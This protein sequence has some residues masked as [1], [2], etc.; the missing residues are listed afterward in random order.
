MFLTFCLSL[1]LSHWLRIREDKVFA[2]GKGEL[3]T[4][5]LEVKSNNNESKSSGSSDSG[6]DAR[7]NSGLENESTCQ[8]SLQRSQKSKHFHVDKIDRLID[9][10]T[11]NLLRL[12]Q[13]V[14]DSRQLDILASKTID[15]GHK[16]DSSTK[17]FLEA[18]PFAEVKEIIAL[19]QARK[20]RSA[21][22]E[23]LIPITAEASKQ[24][25]DYVATIAN[26][27]NDNFFHSFEHVSLF[28]NCFA[29]Q[30]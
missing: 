26:M 6:V 28:T 4:Y 21:S 5:W 12:L 25:R 16:Y 3:T 24:L 23:T 9:W 7:K 10:N 19:P 22:A 2:K 20:S 27:Y 29:S 15:Q 14:V 1:F 18:T 30:M 11:D 13:Q 17:V 8:T